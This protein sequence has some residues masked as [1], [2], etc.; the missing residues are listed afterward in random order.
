MSGPD[1]PADRIRKLVALAA[2]G[3]TPEARSA[4]AKAREQIAG[5]NTE[6]LDTL[7]GQRKRL[8]ESL[9]AESRRLRSPRERATKTETGELVSD[10]LVLL[11]HY[12]RVDALIAAVLLSRIEA[13]HPVTNEERQTVPS[14][15]GLTDGHATSTSGAP[16]SGPSAGPPAADKKRS[17]TT[18]KVN[19]R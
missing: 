9:L 6:L 4:A 2:S 18:R 5:L 3:D 8:V 15:T 10:A 14:R 1:R 11:R 19:S 16:L 17:T 13:G 12:E 7:A